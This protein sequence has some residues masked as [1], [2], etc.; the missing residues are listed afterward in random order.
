MEQRIK[1]MLGEYVFTIVALQDQ[2][3]NLTK[4][5]EELENNGNKR[6]PGKSIDS[7]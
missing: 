5:V 4:K 1:Q 7:E 6:K 2:I 3:D